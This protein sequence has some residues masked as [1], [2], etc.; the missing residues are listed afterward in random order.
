MLCLCSGTL[1]PILGFE[2][3][4][5]TKFPHVL[6]APHVVNP[7]KQIFAACVPRTIDGKVIRTTY[8]TIDSFE[9]QD[10]LGESLLAMCQSIPD[11]VLCFFPSYSTLEKFHSRWTL[12]GLADRMSQAKTIVLGTGFITL[13]FNADLI[14]TSIG[15]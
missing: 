6:E 13:F 15:G 3:E 4:L 11:G 7:E 10:S 12:T 5:G 1:S 8:K 9:L 14:R 2:S